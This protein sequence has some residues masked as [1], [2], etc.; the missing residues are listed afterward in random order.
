MHRH[1]FKPGLTLLLS[2]F[3][4]TWFV[5]CRSVPQNEPVQSG[6]FSPS[7]DKI[8]LKV[9]LRLPATNVWMGWLTRED[10]IQLT[11]AVFTEVQVQDP[12]GEP[13]GTDVQAILTPPSGWISRTMHTGISAW[14]DEIVTLR[15]VWILTDRNGEI[16]WVDTIK[17][18]VR[19]SGHGPHMNRNGRQRVQTLLDGFAQ[20]SY[21]SLRSAPAIREF[22]N[23]K[24]K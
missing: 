11:R 9:A 15:G 19:G 21:D 1:L 6:R 18:L 22:A 17:A 24:Q 20:K 14:R 12:S 13:V 7:G 4:L 10:C 8:P 5:G 3:F 16:L 23:F 2:A